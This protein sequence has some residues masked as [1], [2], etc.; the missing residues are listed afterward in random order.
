[1][2]IVVDYTYDTN[3]FFNSQAKR[4]A[5]QAVADRYSRVITSS[6]LRIE[7]SY[8]G[9]SSDWRI[10][11]TH[12]G[13]GADFEI[14]TAPS[15][16]SDAL[17]G[18]GAQ[19][20]NVY[21][22]ALVL[23]ANTWLLF[24]GGRPGLGSAGQ[25]GTGTGTNFQ[26]V[27]DDLNGPMHR[28]VIFPNTPG[29]SVNDLPAW[30]G[31]VTF[32]SS[33]TWHFGI[34]T[35]ASGAATDFYSIALHEVGHALG[36]S[37]DWN[38]WQDS[39][40]IYGGI[41]GVAAYN[42]DNGASRTGL[43]EVS[44]GNEHWKDNTYESFI[45]SLGEPNYAGTAGP[46]TRQDLLM[47]PIANF[48]EPSLQRFELTNVDVGALRDISWSVIPESGSALLGLVGVLVASSRRARRRS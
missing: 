39:A 35:A 7:A 21:N 41:H 20:A 12:P 42:A 10:G 38:Q 17:V 40:G 1:M 13:T 3:N 46:L 16:G 25:G 14:S 18:V 9:G 4:S 29:N 30:G 26:N 28:G 8:N 6:L 44:A 45:F 27:F 15:A 19:P 2:T 34:A 33:E 32:D 11:F 36:L 47:E 24:A 5:M 37:T 48:V 23:P 43:N 22:P 31:A